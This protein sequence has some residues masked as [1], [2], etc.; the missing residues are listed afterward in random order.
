ME[1]KPTEQVNESLSFIE[2]LQEQVTNCRRL[3]SN[4]KERVDASVAIKT[5][6]LLETLLWSIRL[7]CELIKRIL[8][9]PDPVLDKLLYEIWPFVT[10]SNFTQE[11]TLDVLPELDILQ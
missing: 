10:L 1:E 9:I 4:I 7:L 11:S 6:N 3:L 8:Y 2:Q 5:V